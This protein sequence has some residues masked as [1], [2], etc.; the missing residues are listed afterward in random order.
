MKQAARYYWFFNSPPP[1][2]IR[3]RLVIS[4]HVAQFDMKPLGRLPCGS[5]TIRAR[6]CTVHPQTLWYVAQPFQYLRMTPHDPQ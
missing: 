2:I 4:E 1:N 6:Q 3:Q 5:G